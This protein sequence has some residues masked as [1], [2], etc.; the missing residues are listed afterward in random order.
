MK[1]IVLIGAGG[2][3]KVVID[4]IKSRNEY[5]I[6]G[7]TEKQLVK[8]NVAGIPILGDDSILQQLYSH[9]VEYAFICIGAINN[10]GLRNKIYKNLKEIGFKLPVIRHITSVI[11]PRTSIDEGTCIMPGAI[12]NSDTIIGKNC[13]INTSS[14]VEHD[15]KVGDN[16]HISPGA[17][18]AG[19]VE[20]LKDTHIGL[21]SR[22][23]ESVKIGSNV[24][25]G[26]GATV[27]NN[28]ENNMVAVG[29]PAKVIRNRLEIFQR[30]GG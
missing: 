30:E 20:I 13:I 28:V 2:H 19:G 29:V 27:I 22:V 7:V 6:I 11:S 4:I 9:G 18:I 3:C 5:E 1:K 16:C 15:C 12:I 24:I 26:A 10:L 23:I 25:I 17:V 21:G 8:D 14:V